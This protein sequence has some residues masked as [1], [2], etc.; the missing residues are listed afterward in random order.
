L[1]GFFR[2]AVSAATLRRAGVRLG[3]EKVRVG[4]ASFWARLE[5]AAVLMGDVTEPVDLVGDCRSEVSRG[6]VPVV[7]DSAG[8]WEVTG[9][10]RP[11]SVEGGSWVEATLST[12]TC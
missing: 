8:D 1:S 10:F 5:M 4:L 11:E 2:S 7:G 3:E 12:S 6:E 9:V